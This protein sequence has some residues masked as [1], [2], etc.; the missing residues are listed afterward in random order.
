LNFPVIRSVVEDHHVV[1]VRDFRDVYG[2]VDDGNV[3]ARGNDIG[4]QSWSAEMPNRAKVVVLGA[5]AKTHVD[6]RSKP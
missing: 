6:R 4:S 3:L 5:D 1:D 2:V